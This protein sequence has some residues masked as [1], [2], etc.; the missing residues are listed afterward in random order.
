MGADGFF[1]YGAVG[2]LCVGFDAV[3]V[4]ACSGFPCY[5]GKIVKLYMLFSFVKAR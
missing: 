4:C 5:L 1:D 3:A 2:C